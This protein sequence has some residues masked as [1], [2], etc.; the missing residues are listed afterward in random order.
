MTPKAAPAC[1]SCGAYEPQRAPMVGAKVCPHM[2]LIHFA[3]SY[4]FVFA[5]GHRSG[6]WPA[7]AIIRAA[8]SPARRFGRFRCFVRVL[9]FEAAWC[10]DA[11]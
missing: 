10:R 9:G 4:E 8:R 11:K 5:E 1:T 3:C 6:N 7:P 2:G